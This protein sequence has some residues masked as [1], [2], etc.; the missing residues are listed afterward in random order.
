MGIYIGGTEI[1]GGNL[2]I[3]GTSISEVYV[4]STKIWPAGDTSNQLLVDLLMCLEADERVVGKF[5]ERHTGEVMEA[6]NV[7]VVQTTN[8]DFGKFEGNGYSRMKD[9]VYD[10]FIPT[11]SSFTFSFWVNFDN[12]SY[13]LHEGVAYKYWPDDGG[14]KVWHIYKKSNTTELWFGMS[15][16]GVNNESLL[17]YDVLSSGTT[18]HFVLV[19]DGSTLN[20]YIDGGHIGETVVTTGTLFISNAADNK[21]TLGAYADGSDVPD[22]NFLNGSI[23]QFAL[24]DRALTENEVQLLYNS[25][26]I[27]EYENWS[28]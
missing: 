6:G 7:T 26:H 14:Q 3:G 2:N 10:H 22:T 27:F 20:A 28:T 21:E 4:G 18:Y 8:G 1:T 24:W 19:K 5:T 12:D 23:G 17:I 16:D 11:T 13:S 25:G 15:D 9:P